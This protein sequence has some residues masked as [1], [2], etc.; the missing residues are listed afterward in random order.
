MSNVKSILRRCVLFIICLGFCI[1]FPTASFAAEVDAAAKLEA[2]KK[3]YNEGDYNTAMDNFID[4]FVAGNTQQISEANEY[5]NMIHFKMGGVD[6]PKRIPYNEELEKQRSTDSQ[7]RELFGNAQQPQAGQEAEADAQAVLE[8]QPQAADAATAPSETEEVVGEDT[9]LTSDPE[10]LRTMR[11]EAVDAQI[12]AMTQ[13]LIER[14]KVKG[15]NVY[16]RSG[17]VDAVDI[18]SEVLFDDN[19]FKLSA[20]PVLDDVYALMLVS[21]VPSFV[22]LPQ[23]SYTD[24]VSIQAVRQ[25]VA[26]NSYLINMGISSAKISFNMGLTSEEPPAK[27]SNL[28]GISIVFD[29]A[30]KPNLKLKLSDNNIA[31]LLSLGL[32]PFESITPS[33]DE[34][35]LVDF[36][37][38]ET[39]SPVAGWQLQ[40]IQHGKDGKFYI[41]RQVTGAEPVYKQIFWNGKKQ[42]F[43]EILP[44]GR[45]TIILKAQD[46]EGREK[47]VRRKVTLL[48]DKAKIAAEAKAAAAAKTPA[49]DY[50]APRLW[51][52]PGRTQK[53]G[54]AAVAQPEEQAPQQDVAPDNPY[55]MGYDPYSAPPQPAANPYAPA[56]QPAGG[57]NTVNMPYPSS[58]PSDAG[59]PDAAADYDY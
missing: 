10:T 15:V 20:M 2:G 43:G 39:S 13:T 26:L 40:I 24:D 42:Y 36:S 22:L 53:E 48:A 16:M 52:K 35:I 58:Q 30:A 45:Y 17:A 55:G 25:A 50:K 4:V 14:L 5:V 21:G 44:L 57:Y 7:G 32:Y 38:I 46:S 49:L 12:N 51:K 6:T 41:V 27:F 31:P 18:K 34:G 28:E 37:V 56:E 3:Y 9:I 47:I 29:Y 19:K 33:K 11:A 54:A 59:V 23:G 1:A 8:Q